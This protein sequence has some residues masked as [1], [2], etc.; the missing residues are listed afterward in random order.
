MVSSRRSAR[1]AQSGNEVEARRRGRRAL[2]AIATLSLLLLV[3]VPTVAMAAGGFT[4]V[5]VDTLGGD[6]AQ[7]RID[8]HRMVWVDGITMTTWAE[9]DASPTAIG[10]G[11]YPQ[12]SGDRVVWQSYDG[13]DYE[14]YTWLAGDVT[15]TRLTSNSAEDSLADVSGDRV[16]WGSSDGAEYSIYTWVAGD[17]VATKISDIYFSSAPKVSGDRVVWQA[18]DG[19]DYE[20]YTWVAGD[21]A[22]TKVTDNSVSDLWP[23]VSGDRLFWIA[24]DGSA[25]SIYTWAVG[26]STPT[27]VSGSSTNN[28]FAEVSGDRV[29]WRGHD[30]TNWMVYTWAVGD[31]GPTTLSSTSTENSAARVSGDR[32]VWSG[33][34]GSHYQVYTWVAGDVA[35][36]QI[37]DDN[38]GNTTPRVSGDRVVWTVLSGSTQYDIY[39]ASPALTPT[40]TSVTPASGPDTGGNEVM[41][42]GTDFNDLTS[43]T[44][45]GVPAALVEPASETAALVYAPAHAPGL[46]TVQ[47]TAAGGASAEV[48]NYTYLETRPTRYQETDGRFYFSPAWSTSFYWQYSGGTQKYSLTRGASVVIP[49]QGTRL[50]WITK[51]NWTLGIASVSVDGGTPV[52][53]D[54]YS[55]ATVYKQ[56]VY[57]TGNLANGIHWVKIVLSGTK[58]PK[59]IGTAL[60]MDAVDVVGK[61]V[62]P[63]RYQESDPAV[64]VTPG[65]KTSGSWSYSGGTMKTCDKPPALT[66]AAVATPSI[67]PAA[68][69]PGS[70][71]ARFDGA[72]LNL[73]ATTG[74]YSGKAWVSVDG[75]PR[76]LVDLYSYYTKYKQT[77]YSTGFL[78][79]GVHTVTISWS[80]YKNNYSKGYSINVDAFDITGTLE[81]DR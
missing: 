1:S 20:I 9:G 77:V 64:M 4:A 54:L 69:T 42:R 41:I 48:D 67:D 53:V 24:G 80:G 45:G 49:F 34:D 65:W 70:M 78:T 19:V 52:P 47:V 35:P 3:A 6:P 63:T 25:T 71:T 66:P 31:S 12:V 13:F 15:A 28:Q 39:L 7:L 33:S 5:K 29:V 58:N 62:G 76:V 23:R 11:Y 55:P 74:R 68:V 81:G 30:G 57:S 73:V 22:P 43:V 17:A 16:V 79:P 32:V 40:V 36:T 10:T 44:F 26:D 56:K 60:T 18:W 8:G 38:K 27:Q 61:L 14:I 37:T 50:D 21:L 59:S 46:V 75:G 2:L 51:T 72:R